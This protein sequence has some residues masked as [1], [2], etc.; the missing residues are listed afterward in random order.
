M[1]KMSRECLYHSSSS[2]PPPWAVGAAVRV[3]LD[4]CPFPELDPPD[5]KKSGTV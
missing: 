3:T 1:D 5:P 4:V 2:S